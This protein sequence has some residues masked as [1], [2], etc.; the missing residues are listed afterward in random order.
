MKTNEN[1][2]LER[3]VWLGESIIWKQL[4]EFYKNKGIS[5]WDNMVPYQV[6]SNPSI[7]DSYVEMI[8]AFLEDWISQKGKITGTCNIVEMGAGHGTFSLMML[9]ALELYQK[10]FKALDIDVNYIITDVA[11]ANVEAW[12]KDTLLSE[13]INSGETQAVIFDCMQQ[14]ESWIAE[15][16]ME[17]GDAPWIFI[18]NYLLDTLPQEV[19]LFEKETILRAKAIVSQRTEA[20]DND[21]DKWN[22]ELEF[23]P[24][25]L[26]DLEIS[27][28][29]LL[30][31]Y[32]KQGLQRCVLLP[33]GAI[34]CIENLRNISRDRFLLLSS[35][36]ALSTQNSI[37]N[38]QPEE[39]A[40]FISLSMFV[41]F[42]ALML[43][44]QH[45]GGIGWIQKTQQD[46]LAS[47]AFLIGMDITQMRRT[48]HAF[49][50]CLD[51]NSPG[52]IYSLANL[53]LKQ[54]FNMSL[55][56][57]ISLLKL[58]EWD[59]VVF[60]AL[61]DSIINCLPYASKNEIS[62]LINILPLIAARRCNLTSSPDTLFQ[63]AY[64][65]QC[66]CR[67][68]SAIELYSIRMQE[69]DENAEIL[70]NLGLCYYAMDQLE[71]AKASFL[72]AV[73]LNADMLLAQ[74][75]L[76]RMNAVEEYWQESENGSE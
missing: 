61:Y 42:H 28:K 60:A 45:E 62:D 66:M 31:E 34:R 41:N 15:K 56:C 74:G 50:R 24:F 4:N 44:F 37:D 30:N 13:Y 27:T 1:N 75:W 7:A 9:R 53:L 49:S 51:K 18:A 64:I 65:L 39:I 72:Q 40:S 22:L 52:D 32:Q 16:Q 17:S 73:K 6:T 67:Y 63:I 59:S 76:Y 47:A 12:K 21:P 55:G 11:E 26:E 5:A 46:F 71:L 10:D 8:L 58:M 68:P 20:S 70:Y 48:E 33:A 57:M 36:K 14:K 29:G 2:I 19:F 54:R 35:D 43:Y 23:K 3:D 69:R 38:S 25:C